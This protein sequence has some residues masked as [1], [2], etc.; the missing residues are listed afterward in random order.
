MLAVFCNWS[1]FTEMKLIKS[2]FGYGLRISKIP[3]FDY[4]IA[5]HTTTM[6]IDTSIEWILTPIYIHNKIS[7]QGV[8]CSKISIDPLFL[9][10]WSKEHHAE[11]FYQKSWQG[12][13]SHNHY[14]EKFNFY[15]NNTKSTKWLKEKHH[16]TCITSFISQS[17][18]GH[19]AHKAPSS[20]I[21][22]VN[23]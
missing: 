19:K 14:T 7:I 22:Q 11:P 6:V 20:K 9:H 16:S 12:A 5:I 17:L 2:P 8:T 1:P 13:K 4:F 21:R 18:S 10:M 3:V 15:H 23:G